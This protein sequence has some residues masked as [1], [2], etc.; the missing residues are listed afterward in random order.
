M[1]VYYWSPH[2][3]KVATVKSVFNSCK[4]LNQ[5]K[6][7]NGKI[8]NVVGEW[9]H[10]HKKYRIDLFSKFK[11]YKYIPRT[12]FFFS[13]FASILIF[14]ISF[15]PLYFFL[16]REKPQVLIVHL[17]TSIPIMLNNV[18]NLNTKIIL[19][20]SGLPKLNFFRKYFWIF[21]KKNIDL[22]TTP[23]IETKNRLKNLKIFN[24][25][26]L[27]LLRDPILSQQDLKFK[28]DRDYKKRKK[29]LAIGRLSKQKNFSF[30]IK[31]FEKVIKKNKNINLNIAGDGEEKK[32]L[33]KLIKLKNLQKNIKLIGYKKNI[34]Q[35]YK[36][37]DCFILSSLW[38]DPGF[39]LVEAANHY[40]PII[41]S[42][43]KSGPKEISKNG[44][45]MFLFKTDNEVNFLKKFDQ[46]IKIKKIDLK[47]KC[48]K[49]KQEIK[50]F[51]INSHLDILIKLL[52]NI[53]NEKY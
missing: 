21:S 20:I 30:L 32:K 49:S 29:F 22:V 10:V 7:Y 34:R 45:Y 5:K 52:K 18:F 47:K 13:R 11:I 42:D 51:S 50:K 12:G 53:S 23:T 1:K 43:C 19:R 26:K 3:S 39:V 4:S 24:S 25:S 33:M 37:H 8:I 14:I 41:S 38:E 17:L 9:D 35:L 31:C 16:R 6:P 15:F 46:F 36:K 28:N 48:K 2:L 40:I 27:Y 44:K